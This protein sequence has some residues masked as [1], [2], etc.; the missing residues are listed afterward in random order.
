MPFEKG[1]LGHSDGDAVS[2]AICD[3]ALGAFGL[4]DIGTQFSDRD[5]RWKGVSGS[6]LLERTRQLLADRGGRFLQVDVT[7]VAEAPRL[8]PYREAIVERLQRLT[9]TDLVAVKARTN[10]GVGAVGAG[11]AIQVYAVVLLGL[12]GG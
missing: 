9:G 5:P 4:G 1:L 2:H 11:E 8:A 7:V 12:Y 6:E 10:E 3:A